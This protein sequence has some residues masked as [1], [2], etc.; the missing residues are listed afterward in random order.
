MKPSRPVRLK[1]TTPP[2]PPPPPPP[3]LREFYFENPLVK[4]LAMLISSPLLLPLTST[5]RVS[6]IAE[7]PVGMS[8]RENQRIGLSESQDVQET[9]RMITTVEILEYYRLV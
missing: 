2:P 7:G 8:I 1:E 6:F 9:A 3:S 5:K 4:N